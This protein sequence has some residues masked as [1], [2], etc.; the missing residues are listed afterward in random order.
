MEMGSASS[1]SSNS[2]DS[3]H[4]LK[5]GH[6]IY[7]DD[8]GGGGPPSAAAFGGRP[9]PAAPRK[10]RNGAVHGGQPPRCQVEGCKVDLSDAKAYYSRHKVCS[11][12]S[13]SPKVIVGGLEMRFCQQCSRFHQLPEFDQGKRSCRRRLADHN[14]RRRKPPSGSLL[15][16]RF[17]R[18]SSSIFENSRGGGYLMDFSTYPRLTGRDPWATTKAP[19]RVSGNQVTTTGKFLAHPWQSESENLPSDLFLQGSASEPGSYSGLTIPSGECFTGVSGSGYALS[20][21]SNQH[22][23]SR[24][25]PLNLGVN[26][27]T[28]AGGTRVVQLA[29][30]QGGATNHFSTTSW[31]FKGYEAGGGSHDVVPANNQY[32][33]GLELAQQSPELEHSRAYDS[34]TQHMHWSL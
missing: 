3:L 27:F 6:K 31:G 13:K 24:D 29:T 25:R 20:L 1:S 34:S 17:G 9:P 16:Q 14:E 32:L 22:W 28:N 23:G 12:H 19:D 8:S 30:T 33:D 5:F 26:N 18:L 21:L 11:V 2:Y 15:A 7:F 10:G 4:G